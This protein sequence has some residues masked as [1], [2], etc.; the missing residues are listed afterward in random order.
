MFVIDTK[1]EKTQINNDSAF[2]HYCTNKYIYIDEL[3]KRQDKSFPSEKCKR[4]I[5][6]VTFPPF[7]PS[8]GKLSILSVRLIGR[9]ATYLLS[10]NVSVKGLWALSQQLLRQYFC[11]CSNHTQCRQITSEGKR[12][13]RDVR[14]KN[15]KIWEFFGDPPPPSL[16]IFSRFYRLFLGGLPR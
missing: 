7:D 14:K 1:H 4:R 16:G 3:L 11:G 5:F 2:V 8:A 13:L 10:C 12:K 15:G 6:G 9:L